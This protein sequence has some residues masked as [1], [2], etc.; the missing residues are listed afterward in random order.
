[1]VVELFRVVAMENVGL[2]N[3]SGGWCNSWMNP[4]VGIN[5]ESEESEDELEESEEDE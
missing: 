5:V 4:V 2:L 3:M 1:M